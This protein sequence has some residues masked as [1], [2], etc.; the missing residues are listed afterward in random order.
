[1][2]AHLNINKCVVFCIYQTTVFQQHYP[3]TKNNINNS[4]VTT[5]GYSSIL[6]FGGKTMLSMN[7]LLIF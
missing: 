6:Y 2:T 7:F 3:H 1:M 5:I 4:V